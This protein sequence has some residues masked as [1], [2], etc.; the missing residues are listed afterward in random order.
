MVTLDHQEK[1]VY[2]VFPAKLDDKVNNHLSDIL[3][4]E[5]IFFLQGFPGA[6]GAKGFGGMPGREGAKGIPGESG[7][8][9]K[10]DSSFDRILKILI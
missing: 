5:F 9:Q 10:Y 6:P 3:I 2:R 7:T 1:K 8:Y 4:I